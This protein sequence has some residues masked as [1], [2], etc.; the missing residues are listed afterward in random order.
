MRKWRNHCPCSQC[1]KRW[2]G[3]H[4]LEG[5]ADARLERSVLKTQSNGNIRREIRATTNGASNNLNYFRPQHSWLRLVRSGSNFSGYTSIDGTSWTFA[6]SATVS[7]AGCIHAGLFAESINGNV[8]TTAVFDNVTVTGAIAPLV[9]PGNAGMDAA[10]PD[11]QVYPNPTTGEITLDL[12]AYPANNL[13]IELY[14][15]QGKVLQMVEKDTAEGNTER[16][17]LSNYGAGIYL[18]R[19][20]SEGLP[21]AVKRVIVQ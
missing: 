4:Y 2:L 13:R 6:F 8:V 11:L 10:A 20:Q 1:A 3:R 7:M 18:I 16:F 19:V 21:D 5:N 17:D 12:S 9:A 15:V 14:N